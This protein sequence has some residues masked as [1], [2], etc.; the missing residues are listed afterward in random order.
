MYLIREPLFSNNC[1]FLEPQGC[2][3]LKTINT[4]D[5]QEGGGNLTFAQKKDFSLEFRPT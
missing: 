3:N 2:Y 1:N 4:L 5:G